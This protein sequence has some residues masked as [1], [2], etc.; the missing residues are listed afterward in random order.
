MVEEAAIAASTSASHP[1]IIISS[2]DPIRAW[3][4]DEILAA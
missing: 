4:A 2:S 1:E 3:E